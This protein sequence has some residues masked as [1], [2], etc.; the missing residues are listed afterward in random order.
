MT[1]I[2][3]CGDV[4]IIISGQKYGL[5]NNI[6]EVIIPP[7]YDNIYCEVMQANPSNT[8]EFINEFSKKGI[9]KVKK[10][11]LYGY[12]NKQGIEILECKYDEAYITKNGLFN[13]KIGT[14]WTIVNGNNETK[15]PLFD[16]IHRKYFNGYYELTESNS[17]YTLGIYKKRNKFGLL[18]EATILTPPLYDEIRMEELHSDNLY[19]PTRQQNKWGMIN[20]YGDTILDC[21]YENIA[22]WYGTNFTEEWNEV[23]HKKITNAPIP[24]DEPFDYILDNWKLNKEDAIW[25][26]DD[27]YGYVVQN[28]K[29]GLVSTWGRIIVPCIFSSIEEVDANRLEFER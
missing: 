6:G 5:I 14:F 13:V 19:I 10:D 21:K 12:I 25:K 8:V 27:F 3:N 9:A 23:Y 28:N 15:L 11:N 7:I 4:S 17:I 18:N 16:D 22:S 2:I 20:I 26:S 29:Y 1:K 24:T